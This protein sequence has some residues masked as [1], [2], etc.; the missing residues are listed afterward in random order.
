ML[1]LVMAG[2]HNHDQNLSHSDPEK[3][4]AHHHEDVKLFLTAYGD[5]FEVFAESDPFAAGFSSTILVHI[6]H[7]ADFQP[8]T[9]GRVAVSLFTGND[10][11]RQTLEAPERPGIFRFRLRPEFTGSSKLVFTIESG[12]I[13]ETLETEVEVYADAHDAIHKAEDMMPDH[14]GAVVFTKE[15]SWKVSFATGLAQSQAFGPVIKTV[16]EVL[17]A[18]GDRVVLSARTG[19]IVSFAGNPLYEGSQVKAGNT[20]MHIV[21]GELAEGNAAMR[22][23]EAKNNFER[24]RA[25]YDRLNELAKDQIVSAREVLL[26]QNEYRNAAATYENMLKHFTEN[27]QTIASPWNGYLSRVFVEEGRY[28]ALGEPLLEVFRNRELVIRADVQQQYAGMLNNI[29]KIHIGYRGQQTSTLDKLGGKV[30]TVAK[31]INETTGMVNVYLQV[32]P[33]TDLLPGSLTDIYIKTLGGSSQLVVPQTALIEEQGNFFVF[34][35]LYPESFVKRQ[36][37]T[38][39]SDGLLTAVISGLQEGERIVT[40]GAAMVKLAASSGDLDPHSGH[41]H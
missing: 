1:T 4:A 25:D 11:V 18:R 22:Y 30:L 10:V 29:D 3:D 8:L 12:A 14:P 27:G 34:V 13:Q 6:T 7:L 15:Q 21:G 41:V 38:G 31:N 36:V 40:I 35:Q 32:G 39:Q 16:G 24:A 23:Q 26:A 20:L 5:S 2:C 28:V 17:P 33:G 37:K 19:G 9:E